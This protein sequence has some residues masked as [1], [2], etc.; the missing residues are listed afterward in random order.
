MDQRRNYKNIFDA[1]IRITREEG[2]MGLFA[3]VA[4]TVVRAAALNTGTCVNFSVVGEKSQLQSFRVVLRPIPYGVHIEW[5]VLRPKFH[6]VAVLDRVGL[7]DCRVGI[8]PL[9]IGLFARL[10]ILCQKPT[11]SMRARDL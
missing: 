5:T 8:A 1:L 7:A 3:G 2:F 9:Q 11:S 10:P 4:P 6:D